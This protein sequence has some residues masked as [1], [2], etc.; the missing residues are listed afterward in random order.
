M[1]RTPKTPQR[2]QNGRTPQTCSVEA[3]ADEA[4]SEEALDLEEGVVEAENIGRE[5]EDMV[6]EEDS[7]SKRKPP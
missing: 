7:R 5:E 3:D 6:V 2:A 1:S 4:A